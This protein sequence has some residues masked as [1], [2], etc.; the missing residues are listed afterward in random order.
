MIIFVILLI[1]IIAFAISVDTEYIDFIATLEKAKLNLLNRLNNALTPEVSKSL[2]KDELHACIKLIWLIRKKPTR[3]Q[4]KETTPQKY[5]Y[6]TYGETLK[7]LEKLEGF[8]PKG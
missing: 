5:F 3:K 4:S 6:D 1:A 2:T 8:K 7:V